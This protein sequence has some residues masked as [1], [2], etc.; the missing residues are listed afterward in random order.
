MTRLH[1][2]IL[3]VVLGAIAIGG[4]ARYEQLRLQPASQLWV[5][6]TSTVRGFTCK[7]GVLDAV[8][9]TSRQGAVTAVLGGENGVQSVSLTVP[10]A[11]LDCSNGTMNGHMLKALKA[12][13]HQSITFTLASYALAKSADTTVATL[14]GTLNLGGVAKAIEMHALLTPADS[15]AMRMVGSYALNMK[16]YGISPPSLMLGTM[17][18]R[19]RVTVGFDLT[20][21]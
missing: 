5:E 7:A 10:A 1:A 21:R 6:G 9:E 20:I 14:H 11:K 17:K 13:A 18:V 2:R 4:W 15:G 12:T 3:G 16:E 19:D 8:I